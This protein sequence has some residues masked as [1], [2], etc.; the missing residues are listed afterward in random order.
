MQNHKSKIESLI[1]EITKHLGTD[2]ACFGKDSC[3]R[4]TDH[5]LQGIYFN[6]S[7]DLTS[8][9]PQYFIMVLSIPAD[10]IVLTIGDRLKDSHGKDHWMKLGDNTPDSVEKITALIQQQTCPSVAGPLN[11]ETAM[12][13]ITERF[14]SL[15]HFLIPWA[16]GILLGLRNNGTASQEYLGKAAHTL[17]LQQDE[18]EK[19]GKNPPSY[20]QNYQTQ[21]GDFMKQLKK[22]ETFGEYCLEKARETKRM[23]GL[24]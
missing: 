13:C 2:W 22:V 10:S 8:F 20:L 7:E 11:N 16:L 6:P 14:S 9:V 19:A 18:W 23:I 5:L 15:N 17:S 24:A 12:Q 1:R 4:S 21:I 3:I